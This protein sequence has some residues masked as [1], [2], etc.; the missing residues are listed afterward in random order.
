MNKRGSGELVEMS[1]CRCVVV[2]LCCGR[3]I[4]ENQSG[5]MPLAVLRIACIA[6]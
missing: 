6:D 3:Y 2:S 1:L 5:V 4:V